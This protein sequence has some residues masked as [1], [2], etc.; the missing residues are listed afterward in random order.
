MQIE[1]PVDAYAAAMDSV[2]L[3][4]AG[5][6]AD[7]STEQWAACEARN[8]GHLQ[9]MLSYDW[10]PEYDLQPLIDAAS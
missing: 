3:L 1:S 7:Y 10:P 4:N 2:N 8:I 6:P 5:K 9:I